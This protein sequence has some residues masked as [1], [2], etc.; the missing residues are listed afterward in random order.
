MFERKWNLFRNPTYTARVKS[1]NA[2]LSATEFSGCGNCYVLSKESKKQ[3]HRR[4]TPEQRTVIY[5]QENGHCH[6]CKAEISFQSFHAD[7]KSPWV[8][9]QNTD[10]SNLVAA[11]YKCNIAKHTLSYD[12]YIQLLSE[13]GLNWRNRKYYMT[14]QSFR[15]PQNTQQFEKRLSF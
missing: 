2:P 7:H 15:R 14:S 3:W 9:S 8:Y 4:A 10:L 6:Y 1:E 11:C 12:R 5:A 13:K